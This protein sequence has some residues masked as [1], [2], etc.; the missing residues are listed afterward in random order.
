MTNASNGTTAT[1]LLAGLQ[2]GPG[3]VISTGTGSTLQLANAN[4]PNGLLVNV[5]GP[6]TKVGGGQLVVDT[7]SVFFSNTSTVQPIPVTLDRG[8]SIVLGASVNLGGVSFQI[9]S[10]AGLLIADNVAAKSP[11]TNRHGA[12]RSRGNDRRGRSDESDGRGPQRRRPT[13][14]TA[15]STAWANSS[16]GATAR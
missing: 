1:L 15:S 5:Q 13:N 3:V 9:N 11:N 12:G 16:P 7:Q 4:D 8:G 14:S 2:L 6:V 10:T